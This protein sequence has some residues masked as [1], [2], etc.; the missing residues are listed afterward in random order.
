MSGSAMI[1]FVAGRAPG[2]ATRGAGVGAMRCA[3]RMASTVKVARRTARVRVARAEMGSD[4]TQS[5]AEKDESTMPTLD[6][7][8]G[9]YQL[10]ELEDKETMCTALVLNAG[11]TVTCGKTDGPVPS[12]V[13]GSWAL[14]GS[15]FMLQLE[16]EYDGE[17]SGNY[18]VST[19]YVGTAKK[20][21]TYIEID[22]VI[23][24]KFPNVGYFK[25]FS[26]DDGATSVN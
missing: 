25:L 21:L 14:T 4:E 13:E 16:R 18:V 19:E 15:D 1:G 20:N 2:S 11:G 26:A 22:G 7:I 12:K 24:G 6:D 3:R 17:Q 10:D 9:I 23:N 5:D 8:P